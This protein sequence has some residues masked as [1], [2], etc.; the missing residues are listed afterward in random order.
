MSS[1]SR[2]DHL[3]SKINYFLQIEI[4]QTYTKNNDQFWQHYVI[5]V[6]FNSN[7]VVFNSA[8]SLSYTHLHLIS[9]VQCKIYQETHMA[10]PFFFQNLFHLKYFMK[11]NLKYPLPQNFLGP[12]VPWSKAFSIPECQ[13]QP[14]CY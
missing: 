3:R 14:I 6:V 8:L 9:V 4:I 5:F 2:K 11:V 12:I 1:V 10:N 7:N 13:C